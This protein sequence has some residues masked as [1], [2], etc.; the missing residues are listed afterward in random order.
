MDIEAL[1]HG[2]FASLG[3]AVED[4]TG[5]ITHLTAMEK[6]ARDDLMARANR[7]N[8][9]GVNATVSREFINR[10]AGEFADA[11]TQATSIRNILRDT[12]SELI[13]YR[14]E[15]N[16][17]I[18]RGWDKHLSVVGTKGGGFTVFVNV[19]PEPAGSKEAM[20]LLRDDLQEI[21]NKATESDS[22]AAQV[23]KAIANH[24]EYGFSDTSY[25]DR[26][27]AADALQAAKDMAKIVKKDP[28]NRTAEDLARLNTYL[29][30]Y[31][32][33]PLFSEQFA[34]SAEPKDTLQFWAEVTDRY[35]GVKGAELEGL[36]DLQKNLSLTLASATYSDSAQMKEWKHGLINEGNTDFR[37]DPTNPLKG[38]IGAIGFQVISSLMGH[39]KYDSEFL[40]DYGKKLLKSDMAPA[41]SVGMNTK[42]VWTVPDQSADLIFGDGN[43]HDPV[44]GFMDALSHNAEAA[45]NTFD[46]KAV[47][48][49]VLQSTRY[50]DR[51][52][53]VGHAL[54][55][56]VT[57]VSFGEVP[58]EPAPH[59][60][61][62]VEIMKNVMNAVAQPGNGTDLVDS[63]IG[64]S[65]GHMASAYMPE[66]SQALTGKGSDSVFLSGSADPS[67]LKKVDSERFLY[68][69][70]RDKDGRAAIRLG[71]TIYT[72]SLLEAH[73]SDPSLFDGDPNVAI[74]AVATNAGLIEG[75]VGHS[76]AD[77][78]IAGTLESEKS[79]KEALKGQGDFY[80]AI[81]SAGVGVGAVALAPQNLS[82]AM[83][84]AAGGGFFGGI[85]G[86][87]VDRLM[88]GR[89][90]ETAL[91]ASL[92]A[93][94][95]GL[96]HAQDSAV[97]QT[98]NSARDAISAHESK[99][100][101]DSTDM[102][103]LEG[104]N[105]GWTR[106][107]QVLEDSHVRP[108]S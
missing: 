63:A 93:S 94:G 36:K 43:G 22:T 45:T 18:D 17:V 49:H 3:T 67:G 80:K 97:V 101:G 13:S 62:Q 92:Y 11:V 81:A 41:G 77:A 27:T 102:L 95:K 46:D 2:N 98:Q 52:E 100:P 37:A 75:I 5:M 78:A 87:A 76:V 66:I 48:D 51:G 24:A 23:L 40:D 1:R 28:E 14:D 69:V 58:T 65:F 16:R 79:E 32:D 21:L 99:L 33:D 34:L 83:V 71:E 4:W 82:G 42:D 73:V 88:D 53:S 103:I 61:T 6:T 12:R 74:K 50:T 108:S 39:G 72:S 96:A 59:T 47:L 55:A 60:K 19:H 25:K 29:K 106:S 20:K 64:A 8:W 90:E 89:E 84:G 56:A 70:A 86:M 9:A 57:S 35:A 26:D 15:L 7:A 38:P 107:D 104:I 54:E 44:T 31:H 105:A 30:K 85:I 91:D 10:T 68:E